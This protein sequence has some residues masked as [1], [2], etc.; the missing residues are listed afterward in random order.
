MSILAVFICRL[1]LI[2]WNLYILY[3]IDLRIAIGLNKIPTNCQCYYFFFRSPHNLLFKI[4]FFCFHLRHEFSFFK[5]IYKDIFFGTI[6]VY[7]IVSNLVVFVDQ[8]FTSIVASMEFERIQNDPDGKCVL[9]NI[10][11]NK[12][13]SLKIETSTCTQPH[14]P[15]C[16]FTF[17]LQ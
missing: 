1:I 5:M 8:R 16:I 10:H 17:T 4:H 3:R 9:L 14:W 2:G 13:I 11:T 12:I 6:S 15:I 7:E